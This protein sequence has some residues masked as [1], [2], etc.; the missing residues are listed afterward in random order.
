MP[1]STVDEPSHTN[2]EMG[3]AVENEFH[4]TGLDAINEINEKNIV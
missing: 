1:L 2:A 3:N 4:N